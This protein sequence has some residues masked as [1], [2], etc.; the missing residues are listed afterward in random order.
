VR[1][2]V[3]AP[4]DRPLSFKPGQWV[5]L[6]LPVGDRP[7]LNRAYTMAEPASN[8][9]QLTLVFDRVPGG[10]GSGYLYSLRE[11]SE[12]ALSGPYGNFTLPDPPHK[13]L[14]LIAR[15]SGLVPFHCM[16]RQL[17]LSRATGRPVLLVASAP[18]EEELLYH[19]ELLWLACRFSEFR[20]FPLVFSPATPPEAEVT[21]ISQ[22]LR[23][24]LLGKRRDFITMICGIK[25]F[26]RPM[27]AFFTDELGFGRRDVRV[28][29][30]D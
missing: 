1:E 13:E 15:Y 20:Y 5:S 3:L 21:A 8:S 14:V 22:A 23:T 28:E 11:G 17:F 12:V 25:T 29:T 30:Y 10:L 7:P 9:G 6:K 19:T 16:V 24:I 26:V 18:Q 4:L 27:R 2:L